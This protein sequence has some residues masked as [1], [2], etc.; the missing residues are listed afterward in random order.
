MNVD[1]ELEQWRSE[2]QRRPTDSLDIDALMAKTRRRA[3][4]EK[5]LA[6]IESLSGVMVIAACL[7]TATIFQLH[8]LERA[9][10]IVLAAAAGGFTLWAFQQRRRYWRHL[11]MDAH[12]LL[13]LERRRLHDRLRYWR[14]SVWVVSAIWL[15]TLSAAGT[16][17]VLEADVAD[18]W[19]ASAVGVMIV[20][21]A[22]ALWFIVVR[23]QTRQRLKKL[24]ALDLS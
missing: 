11:P 1:R 3:R 5:F 9:V 6:A 4:Q 22:T 13:K 12:T 18:N 14:V 7:A 24:E 17:H 10:F 8:A 20:L 21:I 16:S 2:W 15:L 19:L 23:K